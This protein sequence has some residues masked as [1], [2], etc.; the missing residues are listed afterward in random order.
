MVLRGIEIILSTEHSE[1]LV[2]G[3]ALIV[4][5][6]TSSR[7]AI[8]VAFISLAGTIIGALIGRSERNQ[9]E[10]E[11]VA[12]TVNG[13]AGPAGPPGP[14]GPAGPAGLAATEELRAIRQELSM[15]Q[16]QLRELHA[17]T[18]PTA[19]YSPTKETDGKV[20]PD[21][22]SVKLDHCG[23]RSAQDA[24]RAGCRV[25]ITNHKP[26]NQ[27]ICIEDGKLVTGNGESP[28]LIWYEMGANSSWGGACAD[29]PGSTTLAAFLV[30]N[31][32]ENIKGETSMQ[33]VSFSCGRGCAFFKQ[34]IELRNELRY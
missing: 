16:A 10:R 5:T 1:P 18:D 23:F 6:G 2:C 13:A 22:V 27:K 31:R 29:V 30:G 8:L 9:L 33:T 26:E 20:S 24:T 7:V 11:V 19:T 17:S 34:N 25:N 14:A 21:G 15:M 28:G 3:E 32:Y 4:S 12:L